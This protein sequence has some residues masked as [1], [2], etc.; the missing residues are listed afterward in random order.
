MANTGRW[1]KHA[2]L[3]Q[4]L[5]HLGLEE[6]FILESGADSGDR[7]GRRTQRR[8]RS[9]SG[10]CASTP[11]LWTKWWRTWS[12]ATAGIFP[13]TASCCRSSPSTSRPGEAEGLPE[14]VSRGFMSMEDSSEMLQEARQ[15]VVKT[16]ES[17]SSRGA[18]RSGRD[19]GKDPRRSEAVS[20]QANLAASADHAGYFRGLGCVKASISGCRKHIDY[21][22]ALATHIGIRGGS[23]V[24]DLHHLRG[25][26]VEQS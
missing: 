23:V 12:S 8:I 3:A 13:K 1:R 16:L 11:A 21:V 25:R 19:A 26:G 15:M 9:P 2:Q 4:H 18:R 7:F 6:T 17:S 24:A 22:V 5:S 10:A 14:I 20:D